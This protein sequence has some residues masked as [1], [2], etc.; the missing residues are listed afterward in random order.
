M[1]AWILALVLV[2]CGDEEAAAPPEPPAPDLAPPDLPPP[3][4]EPEPPPV[5]M[6]WAPQTD[7]A[8]QYAMP[9]DWIRVARI[10]Q[11]MVFSWQGPE[12]PE[13]RPAFILSRSVNAEV[14]PP[15][16]VGDALAQELGAQGA[17]NSTSEVV[18][19]WSG[20]EWAK[21]SCTLRGP[22]ATA[23]AHMIT[24]ARVRPDGVSIRVGCSGPEAHAMTLDQ[25]CAQLFGALVLE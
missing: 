6:G 22:N 19:D 2:A 8:V 12:T 17:T 4:A 3:P 16:V 14:V 24:W 18:T 10:S 1:R 5:P 21:V 9:A 15:R 7:D 13:G 11:A 23:G 25:T 20:A